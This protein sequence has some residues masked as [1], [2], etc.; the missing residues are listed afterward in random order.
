MAWGQD[1]LVAVD[2]KEYKGKLLEQEEEYLFFLPDGAKEAQKLSISLIK[3]IRLSNKEILD[4]GNDFLVSELEKKDIFS[5]N[6]KLNHYLQFDTTKSEPANDYKNFKHLNLSFGIFDDKTG[7]SL[8]SSTFNI[9]LNR[10]TEL[11]IG[12]GGLV[13]PYGGAITTALLSLL[14]NI[15]VRNDIAM[16]GEIDLNGYIHAIGGLE[17]KLEGAKRAGVKLALCP[18]ENKSDLDTIKRKNSRLF[19]GEFEV[20]TIKNIKEII[21]L[22]FTKKLNMDETIISFR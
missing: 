11:Y 18:D 3:E 6:S 16:T 14:S 19:E 12:I 13:T 1:V 20:R 17:E 10:I 4:F 8:I 7:F 9:P 22:V 5:K 21:S 15:P 2:G